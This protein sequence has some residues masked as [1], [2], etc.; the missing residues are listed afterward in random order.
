MHTHFL[1]ICFLWLFVILV[2]KAEASHLMGGEISY[3]YMGNSKY[4][5]II[6]FY[7]DC[8]GIAFSGP[9]IGFFVG[10]NGGNACGNKALTNFRRTRI[11]EITAHCS[12]ASKACN[13]MNT[14]GTGEGVEEHVYEDT[15]DISKAPFS[16]LINTTTCT[17][18]TFYA[19]QCCRNGAITTG[20]A[21]N[22]FWITA[23]LY[24]GNLQGC[25]NKNNSSA[26]FEQL[27]PSFH[28]CN[29]A[30]RMAIAGNDSSDLDS[31]SYKLAW[32]I[33]ALPNSSIS[34]ASPYSYL[35]PVSVY[36]VPPTTYKCAPNLKTDPPRGFYIDSFSGDIIFTTTKCDEVAVIVLEC[37]EWRRDTSGKMVIV[38][39]TRRD[40]QTI[41][42][43][44]CGYNKPPKIDGPA[45]LVA[46]LG[47]TLR[48]TYTLS[49]VQFLPHQTIQDSILVGWTGES[50]KP[51]WTVTR[52]TNKGKATLDFY[53]V[54]DSSFKTGRFYAFNINVSDNHCPRPLISNQSLLISIVT[55]DTASIK[56]D[57]GYFCAGVQLNAQVKKGN[58][59]AGQYSWTVKDSATGKMVRSASGK[60]ALVQYLAKGTYQVQLQAYSDQ[61]TYKPVFAYFTITA[62]KPT[63]SLGNDTA[64][65]AGAKFKFTV[66]TQRMQSPL[67]YSW[68]KNGLL[69]KAEKL[70]YINFTKTNTSA[71]IVVTVSDKNSCFVRDTVKILNRKPP[72]VQWNTTLQ[73][74]ICWSDSI[75]ELNSFILQPALENRHQNRTWVTGTLSQNLIDSL[76]DVF[77]LNQKK[78]NNKVD[79]ANGKTASETLILHY[80]D[81]FGCLNIDSTYID[82]LGSPVVQVKDDYFCK[83]AGKI[84]LQN[85]VVQPTIKTQYRETWKWVS[86]PSKADTSGILFDSG[87][88]GIAWRLDFSNGNAATQRGRYVLEYSVMDSGNFCTERANATVDILPDLS[89][90]NKAFCESPVPYSLNEI[91]TASGTFPNNGTDAYKIISKNGDTSSK[92]WG[93]AY[94]D[95]SALKGNPSWGKW[96]IEVQYIEKSCAGTLVCPLEILPNPLADFTTTPTDSAGKTFPVFYTKNNSSIPTNQVLDFTW[97]ANYPDVKT[98]S[99]AFE[100]TFTYANTDSAYTIVLVAKSEG[101]CAD[102]AYHTVKVGNPVMSAFIPLPQAFQM[103]PNFVIY[104]TNCRNIHLEVFNSAGKRVALT[105]HNEGLHLPDGIYIFQAILQ[106][107]DGNTARYSGKRIVLNN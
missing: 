39:K 31:L 73:K 48:A 37:T 75:L 1:R 101:L 27:W 32:G 84:D 5:V 43:D 69:D 67:V 105:H 54:V 88:L 21:G 14:Y 12:T 96:E 8:R 65:C 62:E 79:L 98:V 52:D 102:T 10:Q 7:R 17:E 46:S 4:H 33:S 80:I 13:P 34:Y 35:Y 22:D 61:Y 16:S 107:E 76:G 99:Q 93:T 95:K 87:S 74:S 9:T 44:D 58:L 78:I 51:I 85:L 91:F 41:T 47:D 24:L 100:P 82:I 71:E 68:Y 3:T 103:S 63:V 89:P 29:Q 53:L 106:F 86:W 104:N 42:K 70:D 57:T 20:G 66:N 60:I 15:V 11:T 25:P 23:T 55:K 81:S 28:C 83:T 36:C 26:K 97:Y 2:G 50:S 30:I 18:L 45:R 19:G 94:I 6:K 72:E 64:G 90:T 92:A 56:I 38:G 77:Y 40:N 59:N 49:D